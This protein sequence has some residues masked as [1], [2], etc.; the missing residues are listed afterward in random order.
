MHAQCTSFSPGPARTLP[1]H[2]TRSP[3]DTQAVGEVNAAG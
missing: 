1:P 3:D 2:G